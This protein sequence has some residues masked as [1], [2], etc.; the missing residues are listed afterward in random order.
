MS[1]IPVDEA[2]ARILAS[3]RALPAESVALEQADGR[4]LAADLAAL[5]AQ[6]PVAVSAMDGYAVRAADAARAPVTLRLVGVSAAGRGFAGVVGAGEAARILTGAPVPDGADAVVVQE[7]AEARDGAVTLAEAAVAG[8][9]IRRAGIDFAAGD[10]LMKAGTRI[11]AHRI[12]LIAAM[13]H[14]T[15]PVARRPRVAVLAT[16]DELV[17]PGRTPGPHQIVASNHLGVAAGVRA[18]GGAP[19]LLGIARDN[20][21]DLAAAIGRAQAA[22]A[23]VLVTLGGASVGDL[24]LVQAALG[25]AGM[26]LGFWRIAMRP[27]KPLMHGRIGDMAVIGLPGNPVSALV[28]ARLFLRPLV[29]ALQGDPAAGDDPTIPARLG[30]DLP[31]NDQRQDYLRAT[32]RRD[33]DG[34]PVATA[35]GLQD[36]SVLRVLAAADALIVRPPHAPPAKAG[37]SCRIAL[38]AD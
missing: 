35:L 16:G 18:A 12:A 2:L 36:S 14:A 11:D 21:E 22:G 31:A 15:V 4:T 34:A 6:P 9:H 20:H 27:G 1:L 5:R 7:M 37:D 33:A 28:C 19:I 24:D 25:R 8:R 3:A 13:N 32:L 23:D 17:P 30:G 26:E 10:V 38:L 29:R